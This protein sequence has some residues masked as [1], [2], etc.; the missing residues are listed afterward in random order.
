MAYRWP[1]DRKRCSTSLVITEMQI[2]TTLR[3]YLKP[4]RM[5]LSES[6]Q[7]INAGEGVEKELSNTV[8]GNVHWYSCYG[9]KY[10]GSFKKLKIELPSIQQSHSSACIWRKPW[11]KRIHAPV[12]TVVVFTIAKTRKQPKCP[13]SDDWIKKMWCVCTHTHTHTHTHNGIS[14]SH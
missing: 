2:R 14:P 8:G 6:L 9:E 1:R 4:I 13:S 12:F 3:Y 7:T 11:L 10:R 5:P